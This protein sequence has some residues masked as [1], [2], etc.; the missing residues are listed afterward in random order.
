M[1][2][3]PTMEATAGSHKRAKEATRKHTKTLGGASGEGNSRRSPDSR[4]FRGQA[5]A[6]P[7]A[8]VVFALVSFCHLSLF[9]FCTFL[10]F[11][12][13]RSFLCAGNFWWGGGDHPKRMIVVV[14]VVVLSAKFVPLKVASIVRRDSVVVVSFVA[15]RL[16]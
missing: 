5:L 15:K 16:F 8:T 9:A 11:Y 3:S 13:N 1:F 7:S 10:S 4:H 6:S 12:S 14:V 2:Q